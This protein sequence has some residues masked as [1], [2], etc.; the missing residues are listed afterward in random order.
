MDRDE[1]Y[2]ADKFWERY[3]SLAQKDLP[4]ILRTKIKQSTLSTW[5]SKKKF[6]RADMAVKI[7]KSLDTTVEYLVTG[8]EERGGHSRPGGGAGDSGEYSP[9]AMAVALQVDQLSDTGKKIVYDVAKGLESQH[10]LENS[11]ST[12]A[13]N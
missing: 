8:E 1:E 3:G 12:K 10:P 4:V 9:W 11:F 2:D 7:A 5:R 6:P 13:A